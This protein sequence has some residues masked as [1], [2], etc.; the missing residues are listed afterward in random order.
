M[1][2]YTSLISIA[3]LSAGLTACGGSDSNENTDDSVNTPSNGNG[4]SSSEQSV[5]MAPTGELAQ[6]MLAITPSASDNSVEAQCSTTSSVYETTDL[7]VGFSSSAKSNGND[8]DLIYAA[9]LTQV[10]LN[11][12]VTATG[13]NKSNDLNLD[14]QNKWVICLDNNKTGIGTSSIASMTFSPF[15]L[16]ADSFKLAKHELF[17]VVQSELLEQST[18]YLHLPRWFQEGSAEYFASMD[19]SNVSRSLLMNFTS[20][21]ASNSSL[22]GLQSAYGINTYNH[23]QDILEAYPQYDNKLYSIY[24]TSVNYLVD[25][26]LTDQALISLIRN[27]YQAGQDPQTMPQFHSEIAMLQATGAFTLPSGYDYTDLLTTEGYSELILNDWLNTDQYS[28]SFTSVSATV[29]IAR[30]F[31]IPTLDQ[32]NEYEVTVNTDQ[33]GYSYAV[34]SIPDGDYQIYAIDTADE[35]AY[36][37]MTQS[38]VNGELGDI[39]FTGVNVCETC[40]D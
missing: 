6:K 31:L 17:H 39:D 18:V 40:D 24:K 35:N 23:Q 7:Y 36:G 15:E 33:S 21:L 14:G 34:G 10:A 13:L 9:Q 26:G 25:K 5:Y 11:E 16:D 2:K 38:V 20:D 32:E 3:L 27:S 29:T 4:S 19:S 1:K 37:P 30:L 22:Q 28:A 8:A 12:L